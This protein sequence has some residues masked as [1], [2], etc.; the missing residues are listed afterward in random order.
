MPIDKRLGSSKVATSWMLAGSKTTTSAK[1]PGFRIPRSDRWTRLAASDVIFRIASSRGEDIFIS[2]ITAEV[3]WKRAISA[4]MGFAF[5]QRPRKSNF[6]MIDSH[7]DPRLLERE[8]HIVFV[9]QENDHSGL[10]V[11]RNQEIEERVQLIALAHHPGDFV[12]TLAFVF[13]EVTV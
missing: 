9:H 11:I 7:A 13:L 3:S 2:N 5:S 12:D 4:R 8:L 10:C 1:K 6:S